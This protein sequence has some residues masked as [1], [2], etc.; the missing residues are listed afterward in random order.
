MS[1]KK[2]SIVVSF[3]FAFFLAGA[4]SYPA[5]AHSPQRGVPYQ[6]APTQSAIEKAQLNW[7]DFKADNGVARIPGP[8]SQV[9]LLS[10]EHLFSGIGG[11]SVLHSSY[12]GSSQTWRTSYHLISLEH[13]ITFLATIPFMS[14]TAINAP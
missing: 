12:Y 3:L 9:D 6:P 1:L 10:F 2:P 4:I 5:S 7:N 14:G 13:G 11:Q 8:T